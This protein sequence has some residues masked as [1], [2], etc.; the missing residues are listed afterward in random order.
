M[1]LGLARC[2]PNPVRV[3][4]VDQFVRE[5][6]ASKESAYSHIFFSPPSSATNLGKTVMFLSCFSSFSR[7]HSLKPLSTFYNFPLTVSP[8]NLTKLAT[9]PLANCWLKCACLRLLL[10]RI[11][12]WQAGR[13]GS[14]HLHMLHVDVDA[15]IACASS[16]VASRHWR[17]IQVVLLLFMFHFPLSTFG[18]RRVSCLADF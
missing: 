13:G 5:M 8:Y 11:S 3:K 15:Q 9:A 4:Q 1:P 16:F 12:S 18:S 17:S 14:K 6:Q 2:R 10:A 7:S